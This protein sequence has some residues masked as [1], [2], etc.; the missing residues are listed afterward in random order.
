MLRE[1]SAVFIASYVVVLLGLVASTHQGRDSFEDYLSF[2][3]SPI[4]LAF[5]E[6]VL[7]FAVLHTVTFFQAMPKG[8]PARIGG[9]KLPAR[10]V[11]GPL[12]VVLVAVSAALAAIFLI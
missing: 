12:Y 6:A 7:V 5:H 8:M 2:L 9:K 10:L 3:K 4:A 1:L 11:I